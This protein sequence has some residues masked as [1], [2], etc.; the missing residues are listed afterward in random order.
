MTM[1]NKTR[2]L[3]IDDDDLGRRALEVLLK[4]AGYDVIPAATGEA[5]IELMENDHFELIVSDLL[6]PDKSGP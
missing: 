6:L 2:I 1:T 3:L 5:A 4:T